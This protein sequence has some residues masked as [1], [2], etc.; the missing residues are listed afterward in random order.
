[1]AR[2]ASFVVAGRLADTTRAFGIGHGTAAL[3]KRASD[4]A[5]SYQRA[6]MA[7]GWNKAQIVQNRV[8]TMGLVPAR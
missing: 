1:M 2:R 6:R 3:A 8:E 7:S 4:V 5:A